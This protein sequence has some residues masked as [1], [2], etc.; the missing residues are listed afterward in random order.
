MKARRNIIR[1]YNV[2]F[3]CSPY[4]AVLRL[5]A[6]Q[7]DVTAPLELITAQISNDY[8]RR[9]KKKRREQRRTK[10]KK[11]QG[12]LSRTDKWEE[13]MRTITVHE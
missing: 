7:H 5:F 10:K 2:T 8:S 11:N 1:Y 12:Y 3:M 4:V 6:P 13:G 9:S